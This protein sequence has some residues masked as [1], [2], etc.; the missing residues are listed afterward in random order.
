MQ[1]ENLQRNSVNDRDEVEKCSW[2]CADFLHAEKPRYFQFCKIEKIAFCCLFNVLQ[3]FKV[4]V[5]YPFLERVLIEHFTRLLDKLLL[6][7]NQR[8]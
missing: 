4:F 8:S 3:G 7:G 2:P 5:S 6:N 1:Q